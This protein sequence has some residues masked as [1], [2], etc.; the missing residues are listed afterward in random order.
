MEQEQ[1]EDEAV[2][3]KKEEDDQ[4][5]RIMANGMTPD[6]MPENIRHPNPSINL[7]DMYGGM[8]ENLIQ[9]KFEHEH[10]NDD[11]VPEL[12]ENVVVEKKEVKVD[13]RKTDFT[14]EK[15]DEVYDD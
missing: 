13:T 5:R 9:V 3:K 11:I 2:A 10:D 4:A 7:A 14:G 8:D 1:I 6:K 15:Y 12:T